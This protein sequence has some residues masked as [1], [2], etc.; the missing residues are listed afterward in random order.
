M[1]HLHLELKN[2]ALSQEGELTGYANV[3]G[4]LDRGGDMVLPGAYKNLQEFVRDGFGAMGH[5]WKE[6]VA[7]IEEAFEDENGL[8]VRMK[9][10]STEDAQ[11]CRMIVRERLDRGKSVGLSIGYRVRED[12][13]RYE[14]GVR[15]LS[16]IDV[17]EASVVALPMNA[18]ALVT[19]AKSGLADGP[20]EVALAQVVDAVEELLART[21]ARVDMRAKEGRV[22]SRSNREMLTA[23]LERM[24]D[25]ANVLS[26]LLAATDPEPVK[27]AA[28]EDVAKVIARRGQLITLS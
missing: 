14:N 19:A 26:E 27:I 25:A 15:Y 7:T 22:L 4:N 1:E 2:G 10:H 24:S 16:A 23:C 21:K 13:F 6:P 9:F 3:T 17:F 28:P 11:K 8:F 18:S 20:Y 12:G 5:D